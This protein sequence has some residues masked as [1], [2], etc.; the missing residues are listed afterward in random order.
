MRLRVEASRARL[1][2]SV[3]VITGCTVATAAGLVLLNTSY[4]SS[5]GTPL[6][7][8]VL[9]GVASSWAAA[10]VWLSRMANFAAPERFLGGPDLST[11]VL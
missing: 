8:V 11:V 3:R 4:L 1:R 10:L 5:Y 9:A 2:T 6:G 7:Q